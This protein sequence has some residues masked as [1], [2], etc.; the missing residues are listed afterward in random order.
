MSCLWHIP[1]SAHHI[2][3]PREHESSASFW[4]LRV[5]SASFTLHH[6]KET[7]VPSFTI[8]SKTNDLL[9]RFQKPSENSPSKPIKNKREQKA[10]L[11]HD[12]QEHPKKTQETRGKGDDDAGDAARRSPRLF[13]QK[14]LR[15]SIMID[16]FQGCA[17]N[18][19]SILLRAMTITSTEEAFCCCWW[20][21]W[22]WW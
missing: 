18:I 15:N 1:V 5:L 13:T 17:D 22:W 9:T 16:S 4:P 8:S 20:W 2:L 3:L 10:S 7:F 19:Q 6:G 12:H 21:C 14:R 11:S